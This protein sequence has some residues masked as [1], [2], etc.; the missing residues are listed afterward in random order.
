MYKLYINFY[1]LVKSPSILPPVPLKPT[2]NERNRRTILFW[3]SY[4]NSEYFDM[5]KGNKQFKDCPNQK[6]CY[7]TKNQTLLYD[8]NYI[9]DAVVFHGVSAPLDVLQ[10]L[11]IGKNQLI[12]L[13]KG[14]KPLIVLFM[15][16]SVL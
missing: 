7:T 13:N 10:S 15:M 12:R 5:G 16:V 6:N 3:N 2:P 1:F 4:W 8:P 9:V 11:K 14:I